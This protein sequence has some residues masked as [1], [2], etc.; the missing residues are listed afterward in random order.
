MGFQNVI[1]KKSKLENKKQ[2]CYFYAPP[3]KFMILLIIWYNEIFLKINIAYSWVLYMYCCMHCGLD[4]FLMFK[5][6]CFKG[7]FHHEIW[8]EAE[9]KCQ[10]LVN[11]SYGIVKLFVYH[12]FVNISN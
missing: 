7:W 11:T 9:K 1:E 3:L 12:N 2:V 5:M 8:C 6:L 4:T 10:N